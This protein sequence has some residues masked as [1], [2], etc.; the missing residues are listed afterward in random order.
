MG[1]DNVVGIPT[2]YRLD[3]PEI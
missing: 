3:G 2:R 1:R